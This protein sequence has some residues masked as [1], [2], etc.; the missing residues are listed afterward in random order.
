MRV[1]CM[2]S[3]ASAS[4]STLV[5]VG[6]VLSTAAS[7]EVRPPTGAPLSVSGALSG[8]G[9]GYMADG[10]CSLL[11]GVLV[12]VWANAAPAS[13][14]TASER[15]IRCI[16]PRSNAR[17]AGFLALAGRR[18]RRCGWLLARQAGL[19]PPRRVGAG[20]GQL[21]HLVEIETCSL[22]I[23]LRLQ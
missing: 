4:E 11:C 21:E 18:G 23:A 8:G 2:K 20:L 6:L 13:T 19:R 3:C 12:G 16:A 5:A 9:A 22:L 17:T 10:A 1:A 7:G 15:A 14:R